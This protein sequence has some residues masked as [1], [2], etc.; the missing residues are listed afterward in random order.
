MGTIVFMV[1]ALIIISLPI[2]YS[3]KKKILCP[4]CKSNSIVQTGKKQYKE[5]PTIAIY[6]S[7]DSYRE[8]EF[9]C[10]NCGHLFFEK[11]KAVVI[12]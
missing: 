5:D 6:G 8:Y 4:K 10:Y 12:N 9:R 7:P 3:L 2:Y 11:S 1:I